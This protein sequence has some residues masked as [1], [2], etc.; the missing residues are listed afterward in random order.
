VPVQVLSDTDFS[1]RL[2]ELNWLPKGTTAE[3]LEGIWRALGLIG[4]DVDLPTELAKLTRAEMTIAYDARN[5]QLL[6]RSVEPTPYVRSLLVRELTRALD[7]QRFDIYRPALDNVEEE[8]RDGLKAVADGDA[9]QIQARYVAGLTEAERTQIGTERQRIAGQI[10]TDTHRAVVQRFLYTISNGPR[11]VAALLA[12]GGRSRLDAAF[13]AP[14]TSSEQVLDPDRYLAGD[15]PKPV[16]EPDPGGTLQSR[17]TL[18]HIGLLTM[19]SEAMDEDTAAKAARGWGGDRYV[20]WL[21]GSRTCVRATIIADNNQ[22]G[23][24]LAAALGRWAAAR[25]GAE[26]SGSGPF[27][28]QRCG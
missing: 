1:A 9:S 23:T 25:P 28:V 22:D 7:D 13:A 8:A 4:D 2:A 24:E 3:R 16:A 19:L 26:V 27:T 11:L 14:P 5:A 17:G 15:A 10:P 21:D 12:A 18:G 20:S 6:V